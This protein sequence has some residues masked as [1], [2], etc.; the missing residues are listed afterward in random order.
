MNISDN[1][2]RIV[3]YFWLLWHDA[4]SLSYIQQQMLVYFIEKMIYL[5]SGFT[6]NSEEW[7]VLNI[8]MVCFI[9]VDFP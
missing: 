5:Y 2:I 3:V 1:I 4:S 8:M 7:I 6:M 9:I